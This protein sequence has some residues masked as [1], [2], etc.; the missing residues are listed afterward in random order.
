LGAVNLPISN[1]D[2][3]IRKT[4]AQ[5]IYEITGKDIMMTSRA[6][7]HVNVN[8]T[9]AYIAVDDATLDAIILALY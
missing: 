9:Q 4:F 8:S 2:L 6:L 7:A 3:P 5:M 1:H